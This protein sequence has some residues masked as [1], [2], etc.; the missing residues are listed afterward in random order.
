MA[1][2]SKPIGAIGPGLLDWVRARSSSRYGIVVI[3][4]LLYFIRERMISSSS[5]RH[6][7]SKGRPKLGKTQSALV[8]SQSSSKIRMLEEVV[9]KKQPI[10]EEEMDAA[11]EELYV[12]NQDGTYDLLV[13]HRHR[14]SRVNIKTTSK[15]TFDSHYQ[16]FKKQPPIIDKK[17]STA[18]ASAESKSA[19]SAELRV[20]E[21]KAL[22][23][24]GGAA[25]ASAKKV[26]VNKEFF[27]QL[28]AIFK[29]LIPSSKSKEL[30]IFF[31]HTGYLLLRTYLSVLVA[32]LDGALVRDLVSA[33]GKG[34]I[35]G[36]GLWF[37]LAIPSTYTNSMV[38]VTAAP[39]DSDLTS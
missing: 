1:V 26:G 21:A 38:S 28:R 27:R 5:S 14:I 18:N 25:A 31:I 3:L 35:R 12:E 24:E 33:N 11:L 29:I 8:A 15:R 7:K 36:L 13:P 16:D 39:A 23:E 17:K 9:R 22:R 4:A 2:Q 20:A 37:L 10:S 34:F 6:G 19:A 32:R 30:L